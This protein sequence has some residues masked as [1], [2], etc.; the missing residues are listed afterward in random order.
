MNVRRQLAA[1]ML[2]VCKNYGKDMHA[3]L[4][5][6]Y[7]E[8]NRLANSE[9]NTQ[10]EK[11]ILIQALIHCTSQLSDQGA[12]AQFVTSMLQPTLEFFKSGQMSAWM[13][14]AVAQND[15]GAF[16]NFAGISDATCAQG[17]PNR[18]LIFYHV[19][20]LY[21]VLKSLDVQTMSSSGTFVALW[22][23]LFDHV[24]D[25]LRAFNMLH[26]SAKCAAL[27]NPCYLSMPEWAKATILGTGHTTTHASN[28]DEQDNVDKRLMFI[29]NTYEVRCAF[30]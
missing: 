9:D 25:L 6:V 24:L 10:M 16:V 27:F 20:L 18:K 28:N 2:N 12:R 19:S 26:D 13:Q 21:G 5:Q 11:I 1:N 30:F 15:I 29:Y 4:N 22:F 7:D 17:L 8:I 3:S 14:A 23:E